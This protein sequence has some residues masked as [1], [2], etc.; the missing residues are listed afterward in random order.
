MIGT[1]CPV[2]GSDTNVDVQ[3]RNGRENVERAGDISAAL[4]HASAI[5]R[6]VATP[7]AERDAGD[8]RRANQDSCEPSR[9]DRDSCEPSRAE[10]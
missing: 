7:T 1:D 6:A 10:P 2:D 4:L 5:M 9:A 3:G 8:P